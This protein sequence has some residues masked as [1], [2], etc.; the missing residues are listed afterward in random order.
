MVTEGYV[1]VLPAAASY[2]RCL[3]TFSVTDLLSIEL[4]PF[5]EVAVFNLIL[6]LLHLVLQVLVL[7]WSIHS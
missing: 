5:I 1:E 6:S 3:L 2:E 4:S 7:S